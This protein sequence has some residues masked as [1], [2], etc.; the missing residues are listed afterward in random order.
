MKTGEW[1]M[2][3]LLLCALHI[4]QAPAF[5][6]W[7]LKANWSETTNPGSVWAYGYF[8]GTNWADLSQH[9]D[10]LWESYGPA[11][12]YPGPL[13]PS[14][15]MS[16]GSSALLAQDIPAGT[17]G[18]HGPA[19]V[20]GQ[21]GYV[22]ARWTAPYNTTVDITG[23]SWFGIKDRP[24]AVSLFINGAK[25]INDVPI[26]IAAS[27]A[28]PFTLDAAIA[29]GGGSTSALRGVSVLG[30]QTVIL[31]MKTLVDDG[32]WY[33]MNLTITDAG[34]PPAT[35]GQAKAAGPGWS[36][37]L[38]GIITAVFMDYDSFV[39]ESADRSAA[40]T[41]TPLSPLDLREGEAVS[42]TGTI[43]SDGRFRSY[44]APSRS[45][46]TAGIS[47]LGI[48][49]RG[50]LNGA[51]P[52]KLDLLVRSW[53]RVLD[54]P[55]EDASGATT[56]HITD[57]SDT[58]EVAAPPS[59]VSVPGINIDDFV[60]VVGIVSKGQG[61]D[62]SRTITVRTQDDLIGAAGGPGSALLAD[63]IPP[64]LGARY[65][66]TVP[67]TL[68]L[69][70]R[71]RLLQNVY[72]LSNE[73]STGYTVYWGIHFTNPPIMGRLMPLYGKFMEGLALIRMVTGTTE[74]QFVDLQWRQDFLELLQQAQ[75]LLHGP[76]GGRQLAWIA[77]NYK[78]E[79]DVRWRE[80]GEQAVLRLA[81][82][83]TYV[84]DYCYLP[85]GDG[86][87]PTGWGGTF[88]GWTLNGLV[89]FYLVSGSA[90]ARQ[91]ASKVARYL[92]DH[93]QV[94]DSEGRF[95][96]RH[97]SANGWV[98]HFHHNGNA[99][100]ALAEYAAATGDPEYSAFVQKSYNHALTTG[101][102]LVGFFPEYIGTPPDGRTFIDCEADC[103]FDMI[104]TALMLTEA[105]WGDY[106]DDIDR[107]LRNQ[108]AE[109]QMTSGEWLDAVTASLPRTTPGSG[110]SA[111]RVSAR[112]VGSFYG[113][114][115]PN[116]CFG[117]IDF[118]QHCCTGNAGKDLQAVWERMVKYGGGELRVNLLLNRPSKWADVKSYIPYT[119][120]VDVKIKQPL[121]LS[122][123]IPGWV[124]TGQVQANVN[125]SAR[126]ITWSG[127]YAQVGN[128]SAGDLVTV[129]FPISERTETVPI[130]SGAYTLIIRGNEVVS[131]S[132][133]G[134]YHPF[135]QKERYRTDT[136]QWI[137]VQRYVVE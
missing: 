80:L 130:G 123:R 37:I 18:G 111:D 91:L 75:P 29:A 89:Q 49:G 34:L 120:R 113:W 48:S 44:G 109:M 131:M 59:V 101:A 121:R 3:A 126:S 36:G 19:A 93:A 39:I 45:F 22:A 127:R 73:A 99:M 81:S 133:P 4:F 103:I 38:E 106:W 57:G 20:A 70:E 116:D 94:F 40:I 67:D 107:Y 7:D 92:K 58:V 35:I 54:S 5:G 52:G 41:V 51:G 62:D 117:G 9:V 43:E 27:S 119:G 82:A 74:N 134:Q 69:A 6:S 63:Y 65:I 1:W 42:I 24:Q 71:A 79:K 2:I 97:D 77:A 132:P 125:G 110:D 85:L 72:T 53:G 46:A 61:G 105:G 98:L 95:L 108:W 96:A 12:A 102:P 76:E 60:D 137:S 10:N 64:Y 30:G 56:F 11:W 8:D 28:A 112:A 32:S 88:F 15:L 90:A 13:H 135:Y 50:I 55:V 115:P 17:V 84:D 25:V 66:D 83:M 114:A 124:N 122:V 128:V 23:N 47:P 33:G 136:P 14:M 16:N 26:P 118:I 129:T 68:D 100:R 78:R 104:D 31:G 87:M 86:S 21:V